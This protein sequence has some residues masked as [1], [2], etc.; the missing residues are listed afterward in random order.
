MGRVLLLWELDRT[1]VPDDPKERITAWTM[2]VN[3]TKNDLKSGGLK[4]WGMFT[5]ELAGYAI[6]EGT[7][8][9]IAI[10]TGKYEPY[11]KFKAYSVL[12]VGQTEEVIKALSQA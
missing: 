10:G 2:L 3:M 7:D 12:S 9:E 5:G 4:E 6:R 1:R 11:V 8:E